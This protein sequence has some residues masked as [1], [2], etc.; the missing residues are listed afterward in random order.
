MSRRDASSAPPGRPVRPARP[1]QTRR[2]YKPFSRPEADTVMLPPVA[3]EPAGQP[4]PP[5]DRGPAAEAPIERTRVLVIPR[6]RRRELERSPFP[7]ASPRRIW[8]SRAVLLG[9]LAV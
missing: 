3:A 7:P 5:P 1:T 2:A 4:G 8:V 6:R 9:I